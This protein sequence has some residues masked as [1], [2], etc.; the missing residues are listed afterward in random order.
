MWLSMMVI[1]QQ[2]PVLF[3]EI[4]MGEHVVAQLNGMSI[5]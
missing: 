4:Q 3:S 1:V 2:Q 5:A